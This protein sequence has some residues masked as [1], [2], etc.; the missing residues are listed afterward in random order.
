MGGGSSKGGG[1]L[2]DDAPPPPPPPMADPA[3]QEKAF[4]KMQK[5]VGLCVWGGGRVV[6]GDLG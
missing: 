4:G 3:K 5:R 6:G 1:G 2:R